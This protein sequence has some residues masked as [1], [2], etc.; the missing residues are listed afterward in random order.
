MDSQLGALGRVLYGLA[1]L[2]FGVEFLI[3]MTGVTGAPAPPWPPWFSKP[4]WLLGLVAVA[5]VICG[6]ALLA[7]RYARIAATTLAVIFLVRLVLYL[8]WIAKALHNPNPW[9]SGAEVLGLMG[10][11]LV[12]GACVPGSGS[13]GGLVRL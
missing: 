2:C 9:A 8:G 11:A 10:G 12:I 7:N 3:W 1:M 4:M 13:R 5:L 6:L